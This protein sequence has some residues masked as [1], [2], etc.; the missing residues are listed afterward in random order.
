MNKLLLSF[1]ALTSLTACEAGTPPAGSAA[2]GSPVTATAL[3]N[4]GP[5]HFILSVPGANAVEVLIEGDNITG[6]QVSVTRYH[7]GSEHAIRGRAFD[8][9]VDVAIEEKTAK[10]IVGTGPL[11]LTT[12]RR[13]GKIHISGLISGGTAD[14]EFNMKL[15]K[16]KIGQCLYD[17][18][19]TGKAY[20][21]TRGC[22]QSAEP[23]GLALP[24]SLGKWSDPELGVCLGILMGNASSTQFATTSMHTLPTTPATRDLVGGPNPSRRP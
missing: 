19:W 24:T 2:P 11:E 20:E 3:K 14:F 15:F 13:D 16:G 1:V 9:P 21:G 8:R 4:G 18:T 7:T 22:G 17:M 23:V 6:S 12:E 10:G 5:G